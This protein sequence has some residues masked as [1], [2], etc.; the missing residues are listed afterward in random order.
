MNLKRFAALWMLTVI[1]VTLPLKVCASGA[2]IV[3]GD[4]TVTA[5]TNFVGTTR[6]AL[7]TFDVPAKAALLMARDTGEIL[8][9]KNSDDRLPIASITKVMTLLLTMEALDAG[10][11]A[12][13]DL[14]PVSE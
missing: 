10:K 1:F 13:T 8:Y 5:G 14:V 9:S 7:P 2:E 12:L 6:T 4:P 11:I 3:T